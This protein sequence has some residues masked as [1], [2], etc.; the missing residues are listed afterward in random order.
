MNKPIEPENKEFS[1]QGVTSITP[2]KKPSMFTRMR[3]GGII[4]SVPNKDVE[5]FKKKGFTVV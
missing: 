1:T 4:Q 3:Q 2:A 5:D